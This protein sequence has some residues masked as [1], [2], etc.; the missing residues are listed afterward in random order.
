MYSSV[1]ISFTVE[2]LRQF[3]GWLGSEKRIDDLYLHIILVL[4]I[5]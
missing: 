5:S 1:D 2:I 4:L 3:V